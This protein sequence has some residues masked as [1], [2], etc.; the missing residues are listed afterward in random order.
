[1][2]T[3]GKFS[4]FA[5]YAW[6]TL[7]FNIVVIVWGVFLRASK[8]GDGCGQ[9]WL[10]CNG[11]LIPSAPQFA[12]VIEYS[13]RIMT[14]VDFL[15]VLL[16][17][18]WAF[19]S[20]K[21]GESTKTFAILSFGFIITEALIGAGLVLTGNT[22]GTITPYRPYWAIGHL[23][24]SSLL[25]ALL[26]LTAWSASYGKTLNFSGN[27]RVIQALLIA[28]LGLLLIGSSGSLAALSGMLFPVESLAEGFRQDFADS[29]HIL[30]RLR[31]S[32]PILSVLVGIYLIFLAGWL[33]KK[34]ETD[35]FLSRLGSMLSIL[36]LIQ[37]AFGAITLLSLAPILMQLGHLLLADLIWIL[38]VLMSA[39]YL[40]SDVRN[41][42]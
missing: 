16:L 8:S 33:R 29:S 14:A 23:I 6:F 42:S 17:V 1:M 31:I 34:R 30:L 13:H 10:T 4:R 37:L 9:Y 19:V 3:N 35:A 2:E 22:A 20:F 38:F 5:K 36:V 26:S 28:V 25:L 18:V 40:S 7:V 15:V 32:H 39:T 24:N 41:L 27:K 11:E 21:K 12:T